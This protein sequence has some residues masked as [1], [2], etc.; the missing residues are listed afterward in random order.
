MTKSKQRLPPEERAENDK[1]KAIY[2]KRKAESGLSQESL[3]YAMKM[4]QSAVSHYLNGYN[5]L[6]PKAAVKFSTALGVSV[7]SF[8]PRL[9]A[10]IDM[11]RTG[12]AG[13]EIEGESGSDSPTHK[14]KGGKVVTADFSPRARVRGGDIEIPQYDVRGALGHGQVP[15]DY[16]ETVRHVTVNNEHL[17]RH[18]VSYSKAENL[19]IITGY[20][21]SME[22]TINDGDPVIVDK[23]TTSFMGDGVYVITWDGMLYIKRLQ[24]ASPS[25]FDMI[26]DSPHHP[27]RLIDVSD[28]IIH[29]RV[30]MVWNARKL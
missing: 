9:A 27:N 3:A 25:Q 18:G 19:A 30:L 22:G 17:L 28:V 6:N 14:E 1:L 15:A 10:E 16:V 29:G 2:L 13:D 8:S 20:G 12:G 21:Q 7:N 24:K 4:G 11:L 5:K 26:S 23:G